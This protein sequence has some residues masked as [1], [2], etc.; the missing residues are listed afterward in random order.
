MHALTYGLNLPKKSTSSSIRPSPGKRKTI[1]DDDSDPG[2]DEVD[3]E[4]AIEALGSRSDSNRTTNHLPSSIKPKT[5]N[6]VPA[7]PTRNLAASHTAA[8]HA[9]AAQEVDQ[10]VYDYDE[11]Y[12]SMKP[13]EKKSTK[14][15]GPKYMKNL[16]DAAE[17]RERDRLRA[18]EKLLA[19]EREAEGDEFADKEKFVTGAYKAQQEELR[20]MEE[21]EKKKEEAEAE[22]KRRGGGKMLGLYKE[23]LEREDARHEAI[24]KA[25]E[26]GNAKADEEVEE[27]HKESL[28]AELAKKANVRL[29]DEGQIVN[30]Q[31]LLQGGLNVIAR[32]KAIDTKK[33]PSSSA[34]GGNPANAQGRG[35]AKAAMRERQTRMLEAQLEES[36]KRAADDEQ[37]EQEAL[38]RAAKSRKTEDEVSSAKERYLRRKREAEAAKVA[39]K[40]T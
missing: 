40:G 16:I 33:A 26:E 15:E 2:E 5:K 23:L 28:D 4:E 25:L 38:K 7:A 39:G 21:E 29:N 34:P 9:A 17:V 36:A 37:V 11:V 14:L 6:V 20:K 3:G 13:K 19:R 30:K 10:S 8:K 27:N 31:D 1:F 35:G 18:K 12:D 24:T 22:R 32:S